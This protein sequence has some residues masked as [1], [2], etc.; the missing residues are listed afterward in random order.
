MPRTKDYKKIAEKLE[1]EIERLKKQL[2]VEFQKGI[3][4]ACK[5]T[6]MLDA[7]FDKH[8]EKAAIEFNKQFKAKSK[9]KSTS[10]TAK[11]KKEITTKKRGRPPKK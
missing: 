7:A 9:K 8:M 5:E 10:K 4:H 2:E 1:K 3:E 6:K 11:N